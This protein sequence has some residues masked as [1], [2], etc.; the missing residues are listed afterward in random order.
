VVTLLF[1][2]QRTVGEKM[3][4]AET[5]EMGQY[6]P[7]H[8]HYQMLTDVPRMTAFRTAIEHIV[9]PQHRVVEL[10]SGTD[11]MSFF[12]ARQGARVW[13]V[14]ANPAMASASRK[15]L[16]EN[17]ASSRV[18]VFEADASNWLPPEP[19]DLVICEMLHSA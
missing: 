9:T 8:Y 1:H 17:G 6:I 10:G 11:V 2:Y 7:L 3:T 19:V 15:F 16:S 14:E 12:A 4:E 5:N 18:D 13:A